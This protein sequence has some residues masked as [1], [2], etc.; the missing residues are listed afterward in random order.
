MNASLGNI[1]NT[2]EGEVIEGKYHLRRLINSGGFGGVFEADEV[3]AD[4]LIRHV[5]IKLIPPDPE[6]ADRQIQELTL[7]ASLDHPCLLRCFAPGQCTVSNIVV[8]YMVMELAGSSVATELA[9]GPL[10]AETAASVLESKI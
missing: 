9:K 1:W 7:A 3:V 4:K 2:L 8:L 10:T 6:S 5:A